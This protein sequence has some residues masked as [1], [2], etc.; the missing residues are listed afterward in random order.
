[1]TKVGNSTGTPASASSTA[2][3]E[4]KVKPSDSKTETKSDTSSTTPTV[5]TGADAAERK[6]ENSI[7]GTQI[8]ADLNKKI[9]PNAPSLEQIEKNGAAVRQGQTG[10]SVIE[11]QRALNRE[12]AKPPL[13]ETGTFDSRTETVVREFQKKND[14]T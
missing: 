10:G 13:L 2:V 9:N 5:T 1:M 11:I 8:A 4:P 7:R 14:L 12:G 6:S 3:A